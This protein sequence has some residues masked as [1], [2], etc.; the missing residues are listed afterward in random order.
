MKLI[1]FNINFWS[2]KNASDQKKELRV[3]IKFLGNIRRLGYFKT[4][5]ETLVESELSENRMNYSPRVLSHSRNDAKYRAT[6]KKMLFQ[7]YAPRLLSSCLL[8]TCKH[9]EWILGERKREIKRGIEWTECVSIEINASIAV[10]IVS[11]GWPCSSYP[12][13]LAAI[14]VS[15]SVTGNILL[16]M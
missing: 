14:G 13:G 1:K 8:Y 4:K 5:E 12:T 11:L 7:F 2:L 9:V 6:F 15:S 16:A 3:E 10:T